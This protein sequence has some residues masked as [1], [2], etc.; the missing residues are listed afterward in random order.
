MKKAISFEEL[1][2]LTDKEQDKLYHYLNNL[3]WFNYDP[4]N[5]ILPFHLIDDCG[6]LENCES[7]S[8][9]QFLSIG[10]MIEFLLVYSEDGKKLKISLDKSTGENELCDLLWEKMKEKIRQ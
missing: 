1:N 5:R 2:E 10:E 8:G 7:Q 4:E 9:H 6:D 3:K